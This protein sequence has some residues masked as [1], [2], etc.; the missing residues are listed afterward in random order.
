MLASEKLIKN[1]IHAIWDD[2]VLNQAYQVFGGMPEV[3]LEA[4]NNALPEHLKNRLI[5][6][7]TRSA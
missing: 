6:M 3:I 1:D 2:R 4:A 7:T 5:Q